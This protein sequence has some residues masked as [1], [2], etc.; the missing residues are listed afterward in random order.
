MRHLHLLPTLMDR[1]SSKLQRLNRKKKLSQH[2]L[3][4]HRQ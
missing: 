3:L 1:N 2:H 4:L